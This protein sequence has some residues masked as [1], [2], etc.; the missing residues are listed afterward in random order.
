MLVTALAPQGVSNANL[1]VLD[2]H[3]PT[4]M[5]Y[6]AALEAMGRLYGPNDAAREAGGIRATVAAQS[7]DGEFFVDNAVRS[8]DGGLEVTRNR[9]E[10]CQYYAFYF[11]MATPE[12]HPELWRKLTE[13]FGPDRPRN[14]AHPEIHLANAFVGNYLRMELLSRYGLFEQERREIVAFFL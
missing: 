8:G 3:Y 10:V 4:N 1:F 9:S 12:T 5:L 11:G 7:W 14:G 6:A 13:E 2:V